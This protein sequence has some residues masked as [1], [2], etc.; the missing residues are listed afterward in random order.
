M[1]GLIR[2]VR[3]RRAAETFSG[4][5]YQGRRHR[6]VGFDAKFIDR[7][8][9]MQDGPGFY[10]TSSERD[11]RM[12]AMDPEPTLLR[13]TVTDARLVPHEPHTAQTRAAAFRLLDSAPDLREVL[14]DW[15][16]EPRAALAG[17]KRSL[18]QYNETAWD[19]FQ[20]VWY[21]GFHRT[22]HDAD[23]V[24]GMSEV[25][26]DAAL[27]PGPWK[28]EGKPVVHLIAYNP[29]VLAAEVVE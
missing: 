9:A 22:G 2:R 23:F 6:S 29:A 1:K 7:E 25:G 5:L 11:A 4:V 27:S 12:Y 21:D 19:L 18:A 14:W 24:R 10:L 26:F 17:M 15:G 8:R 13:V 20:S 28:V 16:E 3:G